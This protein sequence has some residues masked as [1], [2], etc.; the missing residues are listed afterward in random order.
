[1]SGNSGRALNMEYPVASIAVVT[2]MA[3]TTPMIGRFRCDFMD[4]PPV[5]Y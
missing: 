1:M 2:A 4:G 5:T 3:D